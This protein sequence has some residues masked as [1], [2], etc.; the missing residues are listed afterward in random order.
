VIP[1]IRHPG[2]AIFLCDT[3][4]VLPRKCY[5]RGAPRSYGIRVAMRKLPKTAASLRS[6][7]GWPELMSVPFVHKLI[8]TFSWTM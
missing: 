7:L 2:N 4:E 1:L 5:T 8:F 6:I 3:R